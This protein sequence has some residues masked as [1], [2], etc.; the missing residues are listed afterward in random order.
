MSKILIIYTSM[1]GNTEL[2]AEAME[3][4]LNRKNHE[5]TMKNFEFDPFDIKEL[6]DYDA[7]LVGTY[8]WDDGEIPYEVEDFYDELDEVDLTGKPCGVFGSADSFYD[9][10]GGAV[11][12]MAMRLFQAGATKQAKRL[13]VDL[14]P[15]DEDIR[16]CEQMAD[17]ICAML[18]EKAAS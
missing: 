12:L 6:M 1:T 13:K 14:E 7:A 3:A 17:E 2:M 5:V 9:C 8:T 15:S 10:Y 11:D 18:V 16:K 4:H